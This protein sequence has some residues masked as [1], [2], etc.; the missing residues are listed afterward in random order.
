MADG[1]NH[2][3]RDRQPDE[4]ADALLAHHEQLHGPVSDCPI[5][6]GNRVTLLHHGAAVVD[7]VMD[8]IEAARDYVHMEYYTADDVTLSGRSLFALLEATARRGVEVA[9]TWDAVGSGP[10]PDAAF[11]RLAAAGVRLLEYHSI[12]PLRARFNI[13]LNDR[14][15]RKLT[16]VDGQVAVMGGVNM[17]KVYETPPE[18]GRGPDPDH[19]FWID[20]GVRIEGPAVAEIHRLFFHTWDGNGGVQT[21]PLRGRGDPAPAPRTGPEGNQRIRVDGSAPAERRPLYNMSMRAAIAGARSHILLATGYFVPSRREW[22]LLAEAARRGVEVRLLL[23][24]YS[25]VQA[26]VHA[27][28]ALYGRLLKAGVHIHEVHDAMLHAKVATIDGVFTA[29]GSSNFDW[30]SVHYNNEIDA[31]VLAKETASH[32]ETMLR[33]Q[34]DRAVTVDYETWAARSA[35]E[36]AL[37]LSARLWKRLM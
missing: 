8:A 34:I 35:R 14:N 27:A 28:R 9:L 20:N 12:N 16:V 25:D 2:A 4:D 22:R 24:G 18:V 30:R 32:V 31:I 17:S 36:H 11:D 19:G 33:G 15:H 5:L 29:I 37:E 13:R 3:G 1:G 23:P 26:A 21:P 6:D 7:A 10:T